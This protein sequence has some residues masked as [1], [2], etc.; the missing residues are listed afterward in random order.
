MI[1]LGVNAF[2]ADSSASLLFDDKIVC[3]VEEERLQR[4]KH[5]AGFPSEAIKACLKEG[6]IDLLR[7]DKICINTDFSARQPAKILYAVGNPLRAV[8]SVK[9]R[10]DKSAARI[11]S[12]FEALGHGDIS[13][14]IRFYEHHRCHA[15]SAFYCSTFEEAAVVCLDGFGDFASGISGTASNC[16]DIC[17]NEEILFPSSIGILY[18]AITQWLGFL[19]YGDEYKIMGMAPYGRPRLTDDLSELFSLSDGHFSFKLNTN[20]FRH[21]KP[22]WNY[23]F[24]DNEPDLG[25]L[26]SEQLEELLGPARRE[27]EP[28]T[29]YHHDVAASIQEI[30]ERIFFQL[31][32]SNYRRHGCKSLALAGGCLNNSVANGKILTKTSFEE[33]FI[34][35]NCG[36][37]GGSLGA[38]ILGQVESHGHNYKLEIGN[39]CFGPTYEIGQFIDL[40]VSFNRSDIKIEHIGDQ[41]LPLLTAQRLARGEI[42]GWYQGKSEWGARALGHRSI[43]ADPRNPNA[44][45]LLNEKIKKREEFRPFAVIVSEG[46]HYDWFITEKSCPH[47]ME[48][49]EVKPEKRS[50]IPSVVHIDGSCRI[51]TISKE[52][53]D[54]LLAGLLDRFREVTGIP[55]LIN[56]SF[57]ENEPIVETPMDAW[58]CFDRTSMDFLVLGEYLISRV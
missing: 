45:Q 18:S 32:E 54:E 27:G 30:Y 15:A 24:T 34:Q 4:K 31:L 20:F 41:M 10:L 38:A 39:S 7:V 1:T 37:G 51:Q 6:E 36:D 52:R 11:S 46:L 50:L 22:G 26:F 23:G 42:A 25:L 19:R 8:E 57:N 55:I 17:I 47:M 29:S 14:K 43:L 49:F 33:T 3:A 44:R 53:N 5:W 58:R 40:L 48:V 16:R 12:L 21:S 9:R 56:T 13:E 2:H 28:V 35:P